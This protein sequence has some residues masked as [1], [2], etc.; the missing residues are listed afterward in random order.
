MPGAAQVI[1][2]LSRLDAATQARAEQALTAVMLALEGWAR[3]EHTFMNRT[4]LLQASIRGFVDENRGPLLTGILSAG[5]EYGVFVELARQGKWAFL[6]PVIE[7]H[8]DQIARILAS[9]LQGGLL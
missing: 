8:Q 2:N 4:G 1:G 9:H 3:T 7:G 5:M 6:R